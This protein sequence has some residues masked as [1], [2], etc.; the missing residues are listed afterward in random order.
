MCARRIELIIYPELV[1]QTQEECS[2]PIKYPGCEPIVQIN[3]S[4]Y[5]SL[6]ILIGFF[7]DAQG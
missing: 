5:V 1:K 7:G 4:S 6:M 3:T 2:T